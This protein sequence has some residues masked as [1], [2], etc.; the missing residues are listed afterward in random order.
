MNAS[1]PTN[2]ARRRAERATAVK[3]VADL[4]I[5]QVVSRYF[6]GKA[7]GRFTVRS[8]HPAGHPKSASGGHPWAL[9]DNARGHV[10]VPNDGQLAAGVETLFVA[11]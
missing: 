6:N 8:V 1:A 5:G 4:K 2:A 9:L 3:C 10:A 7:T 11:K